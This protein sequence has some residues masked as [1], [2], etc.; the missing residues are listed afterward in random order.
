MMITL[1]DAKAW[2]KSG[3]REEIYGFKIFTRRSGPKSAPKS[4]MPL[5]FLHGF[6]TW[7]LDWQQQ[8]DALSTTHDCFAM[9]FL[10]F[11]LSDKPRGHHYKFTEQADIVIEM[12]RRQEIRQTH[13]IA[14]D[15]GTTVALI[16]LGRQNAGTL[17][18]KITSLTL[19]NGGLLD[20]FY[21]PNKMQ[22]LLVSRIS[23][24]P[25]A[26]MLTKKMVQKSLS[27]IFPAK[28]QLAPETFEALWHGMSH[29]EGHK[30]AHIMLQYLR[31]RQAHLPE[32]QVSLSD[33]TIPLN[34]I[35]GPEDPISGSVLDQA[36]LRFPSA[37]ISELPGIGHYPMLEAPEQVTQNLRRLFA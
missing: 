30:L 26:K 9:D 5:T 28:H 8:I 36:R 18:F 2:G 21:H 23:G 13:L 14:H 15:Y 25:L 29:Q 27:K 10:G 12:L 17:P 34:F 20:G 4:S 24:P 37:D 6:P 33:T 16:L 19:L 22:Q 32:W 35:W 3:R 11:G 1:E 7:S 31:E